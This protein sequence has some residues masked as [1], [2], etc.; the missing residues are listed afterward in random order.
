MKTRI[1]ALL[2][3]HNRRVAT[4]ASLHRL[5]AQ[6]LAENVMLTVF[7]VDDGSS[8]GTGAAVA[9]E[10]PHVRL[11]CGDGNLYWS[12][13]MRKAFTEALKEQFDYYLWLNDDVLLDP[14][15][16]RHL[17]ATHR[18]LAESGNDRSIV[19]GSTRD[20]ETGKLTYGGVERASRFHPFK[21]RLVVPANDAQMCATMNGNIVL[22]PRSV[23]EVVGNIS[24]AYRHSMGD[25]DYGLRARRMGCSIW[26]APGYLASCRRNGMGNTWQDVSL[27]FDKWLQKT[28]S[29]KGLPPAEYKRFAQAHGGLC[30][31]LF[32]LMP[33]LRVFLAR[34]FARGEQ[35]AH[36]VKVR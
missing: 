15:A 14:G 7:L 31:P 35:G 11:L 24:D 2:T 36:P 17:L 33:Y 34:L 29:V 23:A 16:I 3:C 4:L 22:I 28:T 20:P 25:F 18:R 19:T 10:F 5:F 21:F 9:S 30:W 12:G 8:D 27:P 32:W 1:A 13:G 6:E 26:A